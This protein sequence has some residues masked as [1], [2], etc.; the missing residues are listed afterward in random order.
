MNDDAAPEAELVAQAMR[1]AL[2][3]AARGRG[4]T[5]P[6]PL[7]GC[8]ILKNG[9]VIGEGHH[10]RV[11]QAHAERAALDDCRARGE[12]PAGATMV[13]NLEP[14]DHFGRTRPAPTRSSKRASRG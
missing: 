4:W 10:A 14:C 13:V 2:R 1:R 7:V 8:V 3:L 9:R 6:N 12:D 5:S 11:G